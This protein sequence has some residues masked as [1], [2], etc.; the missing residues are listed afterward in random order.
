MCCASTP[1]TRWLL[2][3]CDFCC[4]SLAKAFFSFTAK[5]QIIQTVPSHNL[6]TVMLYSYI[7]LNIHN[8]G[9]WSDK[10]GPGVHHKRVHTALGRL[11]PLQLSS[12]CDL[13]VQTARWK[14]SD[15][16]FSIAAPCARNQPLTEL[17][18]VFNCCFQTDTWR[19]FILCHLNYEPLTDDCGMCHYSD[20]REWTTE[21]HFILYSTA[22]HVYTNITAALIS[23][24]QPV[25]QVS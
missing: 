4:T 10:L 8:H 19:S 23:Y 1:D 12:N 14:I 9:H 20:F 25:T 24:N 7:Y 2:A 3:T 17:K 18:L 16:A 22:L 21:C 15:R 13:V 5:Y 6:H 11:V